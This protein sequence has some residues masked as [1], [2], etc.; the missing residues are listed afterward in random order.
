M[1]AIQLVEKLKNLNPSGI[2]YKSEQSEVI[3]YLA[4]LCCVTLHLIK[5]HEKKAAH[6]ARSWINRKSDEHFL[7]T[8][9]LFDWQVICGSHSLA[10]T[11]WRALSLKCYWKR[12]RVKKGTFICM[13]SLVLVSTC[14]DE[15][16]C[17]C[18]SSGL[19][20]PR[21]DVSRTTSTTSTAFFF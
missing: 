8:P 10:N 11:T 21:V 15:T 7:V 13:F 4:L 1:F 12:E 5:G 6:S 17:E 19:K 16:G 18:M 3:I 9:T 2:F 20:P 14:H